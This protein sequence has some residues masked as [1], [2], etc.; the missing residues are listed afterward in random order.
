MS[1]WSRIGVRRRV[2][3][4]PTDER[5]PSD[6]VDRLLEAAR[7]PGGPRELGREDAAVAMFH[8]ARL[9]AAGG[10]GAAAQMAARS[11]RR[12]G[13]KAAIIAAGAVLVTTSGIAFAA[14]GHAPFVPGPAA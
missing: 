13:L 7:A 9:E 12:T 1:L 11:A 8:A 2:T 6:D 3:P 5:S 4:R 14:S 10:G